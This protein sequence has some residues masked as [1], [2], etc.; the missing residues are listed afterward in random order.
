MKKKPSSLAIS[1]YSHSYV[2]NLVEM[3]VCIEEYSP[4]QTLIGQYVSQ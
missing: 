1:L 4:M 2:C 3:S